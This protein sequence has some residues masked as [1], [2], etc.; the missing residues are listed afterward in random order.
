MRLHFFFYVSAGY[1][2]CLFCLSHILSRLDVLVSFAVA[3]SIAPIPYI[4]P[5]I[6][7]ENNEMVLEE[8]R[9]P[10]LELAEGVSYIPNNVVFKRGTCVFIF[11]LC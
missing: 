9:H 6:T 2:E 10:C 8:L 11:L 5:A 3:S 4:R 7:E 1:S